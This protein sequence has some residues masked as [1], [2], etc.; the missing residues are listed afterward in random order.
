MDGQQT[1]N[2]LDDDFPSQFD[3]TVSVVCPLSLCLKAAGF[4]RDRETDRQTERR[5]RETAG[6][7]ETKHHLIKSG[8]DDKLLWRLFT[9]R[10]AD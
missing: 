8:L 1:G 7:E 6:P 10:D 9:L 2:L 3:G 5:R 4:L